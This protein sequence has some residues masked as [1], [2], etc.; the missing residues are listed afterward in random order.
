MACLHRSTWLKHSKYYIEFTFSYFS[1]GP[2]FSSVWDPSLGLLLARFLDTFWTKIFAEGPRGVQEEFPFLGFFLG[3]P[4]RTFMS[5]ETTTQ[6]VPFQWKV[7]LDMVNRGSFLTD[8]D[9]A[10]MLGRSDLHFE[11]LLFFGFFGSQISGFRV[12]RFPNSQIEAW[13]RPG[14]TWTCS[15]TPPRWLRGTP[16][17]QSW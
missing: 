5:M 8:L 17:P 9:L 1:W 10:D 2:G 15:S 6:A 14:R 3:P 7:V 12:P 11:I 13:A 4:A 16:G